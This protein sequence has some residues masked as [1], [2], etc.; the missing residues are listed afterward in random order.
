MSAADESSYARRVEALQRRLRTLERVAVAF[1]GGVD[2]AVLLHAAHAALGSGALGVIAD[3]PSLP[4]RELELARRLAAEIG[5]RLEVVGTDELAD[6]RYRANLGDRC[7]FCKSALFEAMEAWVRA[8]GHHALLFGEITDDLLEPRPGRRAAAE[9][10]VLAPLAEA[11]F[12]KADVRRYAR[13]HGLA[14]ADKPASACLASRIPVGTRVTRE[15]LASVEAAETRLATLELGVRRVRHLG[16]RA[17]VEVEPARLAEARAA[18]ASIASE[19]AAVG[20]VEVELEAYRSPSER[21]S[22][23]R[24]AAGRAEAPAPGSS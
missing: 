24:T 14:V 19:L 15:R 21:L 5:V 16:R 22:A 7:Y 20:F 18:L 17:R 10:G 23:D 11:G 3:S 4:R 1:S 9:R 13:E 6:E 2:S 12:G 8:R